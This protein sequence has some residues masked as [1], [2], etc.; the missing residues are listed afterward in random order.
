VL[1]F[2]EI[3]PRGCYTASQLRCVRCFCLRGP[4]VAPV[5]SR[6]KVGYTTSCSKG[7]SR[8]PNLAVRKPSPAEPSVRDFEWQAVRVF[9]SLTAP[10][11][12]FGDILRTLQYCKCEVT[13]SGSSNDQISAQVL[14]G[15]LGIKRSQPPRCLSFFPSSSHNREARKQGY[16][17]LV[18]PYQKHDVDV[19]MQISLASYAY[20]VFSGRVHS[21]ILGRARSA[22]SDYGCSR[23]SEPV[24]EAPWRVPGFLLW[25]CP[26]QLALSSADKSQRL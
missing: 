17:V 16:R 19:K 20:F 14:A 9:G 12:H 7:V 23:A 21:A 11:D 24:R 5:R 6:A 25:L 15:A 10:A 22:S 26:R 18:Y 13:R 2:S 4:G 1:C 8:Y 3:R